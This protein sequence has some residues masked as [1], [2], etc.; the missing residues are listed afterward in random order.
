MEDSAQEFYLYLHSSALLNSMVHETCRAIP[1]FAQ[2]QSSMEYVCKAIL[3][4]PEFKV[5]IGM[6]TGEAKTH[7]TNCLKVC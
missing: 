4:A 7:L 3:E 5:P 1:N 2:H 6:F